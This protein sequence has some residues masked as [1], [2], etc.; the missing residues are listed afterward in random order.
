MRIAIDARWI[1]PELSGIGV[2]TRELIYGLAEADRQN[3]YLLLFNDA[4]VCNRM[5]EDPRLGKAPNFTPVLLPYGP[6][7]VAGQFLLPVWFARQRIELYHSTNYMIPL[8]AFPRYR[9]GNTKCVITIHD[10]IPLVLPG[11]APR[12]RKSRF[13]PIYKRLMVEIGKRADCILTVSQASAADIV[14]HLCIPNAAAGKVRPIYNGVS[15]QYHQS[16]QAAPAEM[17]DDTTR[18]YRVLY[19]GRSDPYKN[20][21]LLVRAVA[22]VRRPSDRPVELV[23]AGSPDPRYPE[24]SALAAELGLGEA[25][26]W[27][28]HLDDAQLQ[29]LYRECDVLAHPSLYE[30]F[31]LQILEAMASGLPVVCSTG[32]SLR[33]VAGDAAVLVAPG[34]LDELVRGIR[35]VLEEPAVAA[36]LSDKGL[37]RAAEFRWSR[38]VAET[39][40]VYREVTGPRARLTLF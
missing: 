9:T 11:H 13:Y 12:A 24:A 1:F 31:G 14:K 38:T 40:A 36:E 21:P 23:V 7:S 39:L 15:E 28:G 29:R 2:Y 35:T 19:V 22:E 17:P 34:N 10:V 20:L 16:A 27:K 26:H 6:F 25:M 33:E 18:P 3:D 8:P 37:A 4:A 5:I 32:G 30:G